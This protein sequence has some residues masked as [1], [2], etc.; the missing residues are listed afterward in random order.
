MTTTGPMVTFLCGLGGSVAV[1]FVT[2]LHAYERE[3]IL[4]QA[5]YKLFGFYVVRACLAIAA[6]LLAVAYRV[7]DRPILAVNIGASAP[8]IF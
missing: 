4:L 1:E 8:L 2:L 7:Y 6:G 3:P 5:R